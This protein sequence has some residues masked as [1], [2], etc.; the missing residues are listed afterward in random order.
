LQGR[1]LSLSA[2]LV[3][4]VSDCKRSYKGAWVAVV[5]YVFNP[6]L[7]RF[8]LFRQVAAV[9]VQWPNSCAALRLT[10]L[11]CLEPLVAM[12]P[13]QIIGSA[14]ALLTLMKTLHPGRPRQHRILVTRHSCYTDRFTTFSVAPTAQ[15]A[16]SLL[17]G[18]PHHSSCCAACMKL[19]TTQ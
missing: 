14:S 4:V 18:Q 16:R 11:S 15:R 17:T 19:E 9:A 6:R 3:R 12:S 13:P 2:V 7:C 5:I 1:G 10:L 8:F